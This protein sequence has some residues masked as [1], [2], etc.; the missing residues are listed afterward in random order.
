MDEILDQLNQLTLEERNQIR[1]ALDPSKASVKF[2]S[3]SLVDCTRQDGLGLNLEHVTGLAYKTIHIPEDFPVPVPSDHLCEQLRRVMAHFA[4]DH[5]AARRSVIDAILLEVLESNVDETLKAFCEVKNDWTGSGFGYRGNVDY[6]I[7]SA[8]SRSH[9]TEDAFI[10]VTQAGNEWPDE[11][12]FQV[13][14]EAGCLLEHRLGV[15]KNTPV[16]ACLSNGKF[17]TFY[18]IDLD[19][20][21]YSSGPEIRLNSGPSRTFKD[22]SELADIL[23]WFNWIVA[24]IKTISPRASLLD[25]SASVDDSI[26][27]LQKCF[28]P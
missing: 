7:G 28:G 24:T 11:A 27:K 1:D 12:V 19:M 8:R 17:L 21:V 20:T 6:M 5:E 9:A 15:N 22:S 18:A 25:I 2:T 3:A 16:F 14:A 4:Q 23:R 26:I 13:L 10:L